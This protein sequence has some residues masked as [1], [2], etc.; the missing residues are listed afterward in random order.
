M[1]LHDHNVETKGEFA[2]ICSL[3]IYNY[4]L[5]MKA[6]QLHSRPLFPVAIAQTG[7]SARFAHPHLVKWTR[8]YYGYHSS[9]E[10]WRNT[11]LN[12]KS[13]AKL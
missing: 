8:E 13:E 4:S 5:R 9:L 1:V 10:L 7:Y 3:L 12:G 6:V 11:Q 2:G